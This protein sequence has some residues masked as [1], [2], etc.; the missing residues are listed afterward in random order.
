ML[1][2][3]EEYNTC[4]RKVKI[5]KYSIRDKMCIRLGF[6]KIEIKYLLGDEICIVS[7]VRPALHK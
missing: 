3:G 2:A 7:F 5:R 6:R 1:G 4:Y